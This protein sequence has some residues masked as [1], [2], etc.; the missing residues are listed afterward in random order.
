MEQHT[1]KCSAWREGQR[2]AQATFDAQFPQACKRCG[3]SGEVGAWENQAPHG[4]GQAWN[5]WVADACDCVLEGR[6][7]LC[8]AEALDEAGDRCAAC[9]WT[10][11]A[12]GQPTRPMLDDECDC[13]L[14]GSGR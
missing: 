2:A 11:G 1:A 14:R 12:A 5:E 3:G 7:P 13:F 10:F 9:G 8:G 6:C 4:S